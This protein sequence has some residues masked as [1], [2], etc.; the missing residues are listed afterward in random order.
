MSSDQPEN[1]QHLQE[2]APKRLVFNAATHQGMP[3][4]HSH[5]ERYSSVEFGAIHFNQSLPPAWLPYRGPVVAAA[6]FQEET[7]GLVR[8]GLSSGEAR[9]SEETYLVSQ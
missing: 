3:T 8:Y 5:Q 2:V 9:Y 7:G 1:G 6:N 4:S